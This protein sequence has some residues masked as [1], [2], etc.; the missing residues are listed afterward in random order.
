MKLLH[1]FPW[2]LQSESVL[3]SAR[4]DAFLHQLLDPLDQEF[5]FRRLDQNP[6][7]FYSDLTRTRR[8]EGRFV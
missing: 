8:G 6:R 3:R 2:R 4:R 1:V 7:F 5:L